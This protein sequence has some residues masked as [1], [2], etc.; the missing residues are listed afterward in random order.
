MTAVG[1]LLSANRLIRLLTNSLAGYIIERWGRHWPF[2]LALLLGGATTSV[3]LHSLASYYRRAA[4]SIWALRR[5][6]GILPTAGGGS[7]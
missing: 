3:L 6:R 2:V 1:L 4:S 7:V 5:W